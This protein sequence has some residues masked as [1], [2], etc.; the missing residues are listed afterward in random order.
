MLL[1]DTV[2]KVCKKF[3]FVH[4]TVSPHESVGSGNETNLCCYCKVGS[5]RVP[6]GVLFADG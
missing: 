5:M 2:A 1:G 6:F 4:Q 3:D